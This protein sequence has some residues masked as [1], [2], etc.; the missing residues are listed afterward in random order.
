MF[1]D[2]M[3]YAKYGNEIIMEM[4]IWRIH[5]FF[6]DIAMLLMVNRKYHRRSYPIFLIG[7]FFMILSGVVDEFLINVWR[8]K[9]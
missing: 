4:F 2:K 9:L 1:G 7:L 6:D 8:G 5:C 3:K